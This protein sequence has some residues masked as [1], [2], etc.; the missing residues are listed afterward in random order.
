MTIS[1]DRILDVRSQIS[2]CKHMGYDSKDIETEIKFRYDISDPTARRYIRL[3]KAYGEPEP[4]TPKILLIDIE[5]SLTTAFVWG[6]GYGINVLPADIV[7]DDP[8]IIICYAAKWLLG[9]EI[10]GECV[11]SDEAKRK[12]DLRVVSTIWDLMEEADI[13]IAQNG[14]KFDIRKINARFLS[15]G[16]SGPPSSYQ[17]IDTLK[18]SRKIQS[19][20]SHKQDELAKQFKLTRK[21]KT[22][23]ELWVR[24]YYG[25][26]EALDYMFEYCKGDTET[27][28]GVYLYLRPWMTSHPNLALFCDSNMEICNHC[29]AVVDKKRI[30]YYTT[31]VNRFP[32]YRC[33]CGAILRGR[34]SDV[35]REERAR[36]LISTAR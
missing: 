15:N 8:W 31:P 30:G 23:R 5:T 11:T 16:F 17:T 28:E 27:L 14:D 34:L 35:T 19:P 22:D 13:I 1:E 9:G 24:C 33:K 26:Q 12:D 36:Y 10:F 3:A 18:Q 6:P 25:E 29:M 21:K 32:A 7:E 4:K 20:G 2:A